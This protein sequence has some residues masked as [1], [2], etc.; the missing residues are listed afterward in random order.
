MLLSLLLLS[1]FFD[2]DAADSGE[3][4]LSTITV[5]SVPLSRSVAPPLSP[6]IRSE[7][8]ISHP[9]SE[10]VIFHPND[11]KSWR[12]FS[13]FE[14]F[15]DMEDITHLIPTRLFDSDDIVDDLAETPIFDHFMTSLILLYRSYYVQQI[16]KQLGYLDPKKVDHAV[17]ELITQKR[18]TSFNTL[19]DLYAEEYSFPRWMIELIK[20]GKQSLYQKGKTVSSEAALREYWTVESVKSSEDA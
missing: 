14:K 7:R 12:H 11:V 17:I 3:S 6:C 8:V 19:V 1:L 13:R 2:L 20:N 18:V 5:A 9:D 16:K 15:E 4:A 10:R